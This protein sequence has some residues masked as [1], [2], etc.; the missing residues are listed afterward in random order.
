MT[1]GFTVDVQFN[2]SALKAKFQAASEKGIA[3]VCNEALKDANFYARQ[4]SGELIR[5]SIRASSPEKGELVWNTPYAKR[6]Y[7]AGYPSKDRNPNASLL[8]AHK[9]YAEN[10]DKYL[11]ILETVAKGAL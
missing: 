5:S 9:G 6:V 1:K 7:Y 11:R 8:W 4:D 2:A 3:V 10:K